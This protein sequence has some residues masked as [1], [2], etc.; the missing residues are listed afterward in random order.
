MV[1]ITK[2]MKLNVIYCFFELFGAHV[3]V[4]EVG[5]I[6]F[7]LYFGIFYFVIPLFILKSLVLLINKRHKIR[8]NLL[9]P[10]FDQFFTGSLFFF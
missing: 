1:D 5:Y 4:G 7:L 10:I 2:L 8:I 3:G 9:I 6:E